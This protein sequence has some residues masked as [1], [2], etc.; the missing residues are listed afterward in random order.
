[1]GLEVSLNVGDSWVLR[2]NEVHRMV[3]KQQKGRMQ[4]GD[5][6]VLIVAWVANNR[7][8]INR[9]SQQILK[10]ATAFDQELDWISR[11]VQL[12]VAVWSASVNGVQIKEGSA[13]VL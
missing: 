13:S 8:M 5:H 3:M 7:H 12:R 4:A 6:H 10:R 2:S 11:I 1:M 9:I